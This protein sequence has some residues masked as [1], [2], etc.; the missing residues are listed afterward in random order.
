MSAVRTDDDRVTEAERN[1]KEAL[2][3]Y[4]ENVARQIR[5]I[6]D[7]GSMKVVT[8]DEILAAKKSA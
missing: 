6:K 4:G 8:R 7:S 3:D 1:L 2:V 5:S